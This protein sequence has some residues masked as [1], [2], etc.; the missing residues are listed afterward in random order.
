MAKENRTETIRIRVTPN[1]K[2]ILENECKRANISISTFFRMYFL[3]V[4]NYQFKTTT[5][6][7]SR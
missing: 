5:D 6:A 1:E 7:I 4:M 2:A 3:N